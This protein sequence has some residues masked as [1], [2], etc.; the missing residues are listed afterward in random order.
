[1]EGALLI[2]KP[3]GLTS[4]R[5]VEEVKRKLRVKK[6][7]HT[8]TLDPIATGLLILL[9]GRAT[10]FAQFLINFPKTYEF[11][12]RFGAQTDTYDAQG[13]ITKRY[14]GELKCEKLRSVLEEFRGEIEQV[15]PPFS[16]KKVKGRRAYELARKG[17]P[18]ELKPVKVKVYSLEL[19][20]CDEAQKKARLLAE[21]SSGAY[22]R[23]LAHDI[24]QRLGIGAFV[25]ELRRTKVDEISVEEAVSLEEFL[26]SERPE[27]FLIPVDNLF[28]IIPEVRLSSFDAGKILKGQSI[29][30][31]ERD[32]EGLVK[33]YDNGKFIGIGE[34][35][36]GVLKPKRLLV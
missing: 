17:K 20:E 7:G 9:V 27:R 19:L 5:V 22:V 13:K 25:E 31:R 35:R 12:L 36:G 26:S 6:V 23:S 15:P 3:K 28:R 11:T 2:D 1:M 29:L 4:T 30:V 16:A 8:G 33:I 24:G 10:R 32:Y 14:E 34:L 18:V 21:L